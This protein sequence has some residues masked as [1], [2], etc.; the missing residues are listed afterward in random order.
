MNGLHPYGHHTNGYIC[1]DNLH[2]A[3]MLTDTVSGIPY[4]LLASIFT[5]YTI[6]MDT[7]VLTSRSR[8][9]WDLKYS[10]LQ[11]RQCSC[12]FFWSD[13][14]SR[15]LPWRL[16]WNLWDSRE[17]LFES[18]GDS[19]EFLFE[20]WQSWVF[21]VRSPPPVVTHGVHPYFAWS[22]HTLNELW[23]N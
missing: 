21:K 10:D 17:N 19:R 14:D 2:M 1:T 12:L 13:G 9:R 16:F 15:L 8:G 11:I 5:H 23:L 7:S 3:Y 6:Q 22:E 20:V 18:Y 4:T